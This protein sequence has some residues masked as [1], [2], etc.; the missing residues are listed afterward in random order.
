MTFAAI[1]MGIRLA[2]RRSGFF[3]KRYAPQILVGTGVAGF[4]ATAVVSGKAALKAKDILDEKDAKIEEIEAVKEDGDPTY[5]LADYEQD[6]KIVKTKTVWKLVKTF[7]PPITLGAASAALVFGGHR[8]LGRRAAAALASAYEAQTKLRKYRENVVDQLGG[9]IDQKLAEGLKIDRLET[10]EN[11]KKL[12]EEKRD[13]PAKKVEDGYTIVEWT[14][15]ETTC[16]GKYGLGGTWK[17]DPY[18]LLLKLYD[19][20]NFASDRLTINHSIEINDILKDEFGADKIKGGTKGFIRDE[21]LGMVDAMDWG[22]DDLFTVE[23]KEAFLRSGQT[24]ITLRFKVRNQ[25]VEEYYD[26]IN[27][28]HSRNDRQLAESI[29]RYKKI[30]PRLRH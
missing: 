5:T 16:G 10:S 26:A 22:V 3:L 7:A 30:T 17:P 6:K 27:N 8:M 14:F 9:E 24:Y 29:M 11:L 18:Y 23:G 15:D 12:E 19:A 21:K 13:L 28:A 1:K 20:Y 25:P 2:F 4:A